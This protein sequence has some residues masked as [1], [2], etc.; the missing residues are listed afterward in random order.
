ML[1]KL[2]LVNSSQWGIL[3]LPSGE[4]LK[5]IKSMLRMISK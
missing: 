3:V 1:A 2:M 4:I 5:D